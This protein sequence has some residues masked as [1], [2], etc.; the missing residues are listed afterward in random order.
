MSMYGGG[1]DALIRRLYATIT[2]LTILL[3]LA[4]LLSGLVQ[5]KP[6]TKQ[7]FGCTLS[8]HPLITTRY[9]QVEEPILPRQCHG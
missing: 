1:D 9:V 3:I 7:D 5:F 4:V 6:F 2:V 8:Y